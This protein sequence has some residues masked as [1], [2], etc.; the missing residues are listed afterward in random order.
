MKIKNYI[1]LALF[2]VLPL[3]SQEK[4]EMA[5][6]IHITGDELIGYEEKG[7]RMREVVGHVVLTHGN[8]VITCDRA[9]QYIKLNDARLIGNVVVTQDTLTI[10]TPEGFYYGN[11][12]Y[13]Y[14]EKGVTLDD[15]KVVLT[16]DTGKYLFNENKAEFRG[17][18]KLTD[19][20]NV[21][22][23]LDLDYFRRE[24]RAVAWNSVKIVD[25]VNTIYSDSLI[26]M[27]KL[28]TTDGFGNI[29]IHNSHDNVYIFGQRLF[30]DR[31]K[32][33]SRIDKKPF[34]IQIDTTTSGV[35]DTFYI[36]SVLMETFRDSA[37][38]FIAT[39]SVQLLRGTFSSRNDKTVYDRKHSEII[40]A[41]IGEEG[42]Q[43][44]IWNDNVQLTGD[45]I[46]VKM[47]KNSIKLID[48]VNNTLTVS[49][50]LKFPA[51]YDQ[52]SGGRLVM[53]FDTLGLNLTEVFG[54]VL[55]YY[56]M[57]DDSTSKGVVKASS[58]DAKIYFENK[59]VA[60]V[61]LFVD[62]KSEYHPENLIKG[63]EKKFLLP[64]FELFEN[65]PVKGDLLRGVTIK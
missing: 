4:G 8:I 55:S 2:F 7:E 56:Y 5:D 53:H 37:E 38:R 23:S 21:L 51:R 63:N 65:H 40:T 48:V 3:F 27:R 17:K 60:S 42:K 30:D 59:K 39:D 11:K 58:K 41:K 49:K 29:Q 9:I 15:R 52:I 33:Y 19:K 12:R 1:F 35:I 16:A 45:S 20:V 47:Q 32:N 46:S 22:T 24:D 25:S 14:S 13:A 54:N 28:R 64:R 31:N 50:N 44:I 6:K 36:K 57:Y 10:K 43:P 62:P 34:L 18:V 26:F 61:K